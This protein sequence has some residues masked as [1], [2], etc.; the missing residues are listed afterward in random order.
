MLNHELR[1]SIYE[2][3]IKRTEQI[4]EKVPLSDFLNE[5]ILQHIQQKFIKSLGQEVSFEQLQE[6]LLRTPLTIAQIELVVLQ[7]QQHKAIDS[8]LTSLL[9]ISLK[10]FSM[11]QEK[12]TI[13]KKCKEKLDFVLDQ[14]ED[15]LT[16]LVS[17]K[18][19]AP[20]IAKIF[21]LLVA[22]MKAYVET[23]HIN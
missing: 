12:N 17:H 2:R 14:T 21:I 22:G 19:I 1:N 13:T 11:V 7:L 18:R 23:I 3:S 4:L 6:I 9:C 15:T 8:D 10:R 20:E 16:D 5:K